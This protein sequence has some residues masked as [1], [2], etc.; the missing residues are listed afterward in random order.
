MITNVFKK[1]KLFYTSESI[2]CLRSTTL[3]LH[4]VKKVGTNSDAA[5]CKQHGQFM[6]WTVGYNEGR[7]CELGSEVQILNIKLY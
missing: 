6:Q 3:K 2:K 1:L 5:K 7:S 4:F